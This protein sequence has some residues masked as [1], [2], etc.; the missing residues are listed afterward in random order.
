MGGAGRGEGADGT[1]NTRQRKG[2]ERQPFWCTRTCKC[3]DMG[4]DDIE[5]GTKEKNVMGAQ[6]HILGEGVITA[7]DRNPRKKKNMI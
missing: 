1:W 7:Y 3:R 4:S 6:T 2:K 5:N